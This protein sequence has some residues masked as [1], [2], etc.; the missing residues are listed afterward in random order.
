[1]GTR[2]A[3][4]EA[5][6][7]ARLELKKEIRKAQERSW[8]ELCRSVDSDPWGVSY[9]LVTKRLGRRSP[10]MDQAARVC[11][12]RGLF[13]QS[14]RTDWESIPT[15]GGATATY[16]ILPD[17]PLGIPLFTADEVARVVS[18]LPTGKAPGPDLIP[19]ELIKLTFKKFPDV[20]VDCYNACLLEGTFPTPWKRAKLVLLHKGKGKPKNV[21]S[22]YR[23]ISLLDGS[24][25]VLERL[26]L[27]RLIRHIDSVG[28]LSDLQFGFRRSRSTVDAIQQVLS[29]AKAAGSG[30]VQKKECLGDD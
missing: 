8:S 28:A 6:K 5:Y 23:P 3:E 24:G 1:M 29:A 15:S 25:K 17:A 30:A 14:P 19:Y 13:P 12:A 21:P 4:L 20:F 27:E 18:K 7:K 22:S 10:A 26:L 9:R 11:V 2:E 16:A